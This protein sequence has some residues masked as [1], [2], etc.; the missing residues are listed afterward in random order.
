M[1]APTKMSGMAD[2]NRPLAQIPTVLIFGQRPSTL[3]D[4]LKLLSHQAGIRRL[5]GNFFAVV[6]DWL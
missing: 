2:A 3:L 4:C 6:Y 5:T 1:T